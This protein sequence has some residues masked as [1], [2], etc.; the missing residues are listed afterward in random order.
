MFYIWCGERNKSR[1]LRGPWYTMDGVVLSVR[2]GQNH[3]SNFFILISR[4]LCN[5]NRIYRGFFVGIEETWNQ[6]ILP[7]LQKKHF[8]SIILSAFKHP[9]TFQC[10]KRDETGSLFAS[11]TPCVS[12]FNYHGHSGLRT[13][14]AGYCVMVS[15]TGNGRSG[16]WRRHE[17]WRPGKTVCIRYGS[18]AQ[19]RRP[20]RRRRRTCRISVP[21]VVQDGSERTYLRGAGH[22]GGSQTVPNRAS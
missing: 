9:G 10:R 2:T 14:S 13:S 19:T 12:R 16:H 6:V 20:C 7:G 11:V 15:G 17:K 4:P 21:T 22:H 3:P 18:N 1:R 5:T 8:F